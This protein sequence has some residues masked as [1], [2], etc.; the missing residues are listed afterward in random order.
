MRTVYGR[1]L[2]ARSGRRDAPG[3]GAPRRPTADAA[4]RRRLVSD[5]TRAGAA[6]GRVPTP[7]LPRPRRDRV[8]RARPRGVEFEFEAHLL[9]EDSETLEQLPVLPTWSRAATAR[10]VTR[11][12]RALRQRAPQPRRLR[13]GHDRPAARLRPL[14]LPLAPRGKGRWRFWVSGSGSSLTRTHHPKHQ[15]PTMS[16]LNPFFLLGLAAWRRRC[17]CIWCGARGRGGWS[18]RALLRAAG[19]AAHHP[20]ATLRD[21][22]RGAQVLALLLVVFAFTRRTSAARAGR[23]SRGRARP[24]SDDA[25]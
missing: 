18:S 16:F 5:F 23:R 22:L 8:P 4:R 14:L 24:S 25:S 2:D 3:R 17:W 12:R 21:L 10:R 19:A 13:A 15:H 7:P 11:A 6:R 9:L 1:T 20:A